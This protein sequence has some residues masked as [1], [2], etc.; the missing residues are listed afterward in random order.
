MARILVIDDD[1]L[2]RSILREILSPL[3]HTIVE[4]P[5][6]RE[7]VDSYSHS[8]AD[9]VITDIV[10]PEEDGLEAI[11]EIHQQNPLA[12]VIAMTGF[13]VDGEKGYLTLA[14]KYGATQTL[15]KPLYKD[16][17]LHAVETA[18]AT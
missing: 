12:K 7:G 5:G 6:G 4:A 3:G 9:L 17:V 2:T 8:P 11:Q 15:R 1:G 18:L 16:N 10:M 14:E 13:D